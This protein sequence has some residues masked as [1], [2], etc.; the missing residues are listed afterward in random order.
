MLERLT[1]NATSPVCHKYRTASFW[2]GLLFCP[3]YTL[4]TFPIFFTPHRNTSTTLRRHMYGTVPDLW[5]AAGLLPASAD[6][7]PLWHVCRLIRHSDDT[8]Y[9]VCHPSAVSDDRREAATDS[10]RDRRASPCVVLCV[11]YRCQSEI[12]T[13]EFRFCPM[14]KSEFGCTRAAGFGQFRKTILMDNV[15]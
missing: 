2:A 1:I 8:G 10:S 13:P 12:G 3:P 7:P 11:E 4:N 6:H 14:S 15:S 9:V 5:R